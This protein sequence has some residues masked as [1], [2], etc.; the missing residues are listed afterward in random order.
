VLLNV[1]PAAFSAAAG[2]NSAGGLPKLKESHERHADMAMQHQQQAAAKRAREAAQNNALAA[3][4]R[5]RDSYRRH[6]ASAHR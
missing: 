3:S 2:T 6:P 4:F 5:H 1:A